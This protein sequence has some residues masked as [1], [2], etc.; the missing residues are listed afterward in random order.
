MIYPP[1]SVRCFKLTNQIS[2]KSASQIGLKSANQIEVCLPSSA[3][4]GH[5]ADKLAMAKDTLL[6]L[7]LSNYFLGHFEAVVT[8]S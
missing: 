5:R 8:E 1:F 6:S 2:F 3:D 4:A 7:L